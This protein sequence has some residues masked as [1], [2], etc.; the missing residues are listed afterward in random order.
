MQKRKKKISKRKPARSTALALRPRQ[1]VQLVMNDKAGRLSEPESIAGLA[2]APVTLQSDPLMIVAMVGKLKL[3]K[4]QIAALRR[5]VED[6]EVDWRPLEKGGPAIIPYLSHNGC[7]DRLDACF[8]LGG[9]GMAPMGQPKEKDGVIYVPYALIVDGSPRVF[10]WG[11]QA[12]HANNKQMTYGDA[13]EGA[14][15]NAITR[16][17]KELGVGRDLWSKSYI[18]ALKARAGVRAAR[19]RESEQAKQ[20]GPSTYGSDAKG[21]E[22]IT[23]K[24]RQRLFTIASKMGREERD[25]KLW[26]KARYNLETTKDIKRRDYNEII[27]SIEKPGSLLADPMLWR[28]TT[29]PGEGG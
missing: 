15:S 10:A 23:Q 5:P 7:R 9:W 22:P 28:Q 27:A 12:Y 17:G 25:I 21:G 14:K 8:G 4:D 24:Q 26:L 13:L 2:P 1:V 19:E 3:T 6:S 16:C 11:E 29:E 20:P 18:T